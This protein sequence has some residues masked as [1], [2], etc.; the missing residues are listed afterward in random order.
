MCQKILTRIK[1]PLSKPF[2]SINICFWLRYKWVVS[3]NLWK[4]WAEKIGSNEP[5]K[6]QIYK[7]EGPPGA[8]GAALRTCK[9]QSLDPIPGSAR[10]CPRRKAGKGRTCPF[11]AKQDNPWTLC[12]EAFAAYPRTSCS[13]IPRSSWQR[14]RSIYA[15]FCFWRLRIVC[16][17]R[18]ISSCHFPGML[19]AP[20]SSSTLFRT[21]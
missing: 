3:S 12:Q 15:V 4:N 13:G 18:K 21:L 1:S 19:S 10:T 2:D 8:Q 20:S 7:T 17:P 9:G 5:W 11:S 16:W 14:F 6:L